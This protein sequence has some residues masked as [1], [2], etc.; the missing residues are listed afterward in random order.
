MDP[1]PKAEHEKRLSKASKGRG[2]SWRVD[3]VDWRICDAYDE[4]APVAEELVE[5]TAEGSSWHLVE[6]TD[7]RYRDVHSAERVLAGLESVLSREESEANETRPAAVSVPEPS[8]LDG[9]DLARTIDPDDYKKELAKQQRRLAKFAARASEAEIRTILVFEGWDAAGKGGA[10]RRLTHALDARD[11]DLVPIAAPSEEE[12]RYHY[13]WRFWRRV[14]RAGRMVIF[15]RS[16]Y[17]RVLVE[18]VEGFA[19]EDEW[20]RAYAEIN[21]FERETRRATGSVVHKFW[22]HIDPDEQLR[23]FRGQGAERPTRSTRSPT[24]TT[25]TAT[26]GTPTWPRST[27]WW[28]TP[29]RARPR[30]SSWPRTTNAP[31]G[32][33]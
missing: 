29:A 25:A 32:S 9:V 24:R 13:L 14:P 19:R 12:L 31:R 27:T 6:A 11:V 21:E 5:R 3:E 23:R 33:R 30:G 7:A 17:G 18:R 2:E 16:W 28:N 1:S 4:M 26:A 8:V 15:D 20:Q 10:I 22:L